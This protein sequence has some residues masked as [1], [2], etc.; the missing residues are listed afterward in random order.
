MHYRKEKKE[1]TQ[2]QRRQNETAVV[3]HAFLVPERPHSIDRSLSISMECV[4][5]IHNA[6]STV[7]ANTGMRAGTVIYWS[8]PVQE[9]EYHEQSKSERLYQ[10]KA[11]YGLLV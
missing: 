8:L 3:T 1:H 6:G 7:R 4:H 9:H 10:L 5:S 11:L 2:L